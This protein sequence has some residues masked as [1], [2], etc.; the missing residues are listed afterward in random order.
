MLPEPLFSTSRNPPFFATDK[1]PVLKYQLVLTSHGVSLH[2]VVRV[3]FACPLPAD[4][5]R[6][7]LGQRGVHTSAHPL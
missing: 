2:E 3:V 7:I 1:T 6:S 5:W 4:R